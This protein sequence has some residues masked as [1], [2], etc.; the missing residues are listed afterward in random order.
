MLRVSQ[1]QSDDTQSQTLTI[2]SRKRQLTLH[3]K[4]A[5]VPDPRLGVQAPKIFAFDHVFSA[6]EPQ[7][8]IL[9]LII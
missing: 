2:D 5:S 3:H 7:V 4:N 6:S 9:L 1:G 8:C